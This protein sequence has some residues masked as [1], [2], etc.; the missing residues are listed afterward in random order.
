MAEAAI[1]MTTERL[2]DNYNINDDVDAVM[3]MTMHG[4][5]GLEFDKVIIPD[6]NEG[7]IPHNMSTSDEQIEEERRMMYVAMTRAKTR[8]HLFYTEHRYNRDYIPSRFIREI[9]E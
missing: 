3:C 9:A 6:V 7:I 2:K 5:K 4:S 8:L 1:F